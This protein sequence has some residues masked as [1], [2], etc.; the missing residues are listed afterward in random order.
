MSL[1]IAGFVSSQVQ[2]PGQ[3][4]KT[5]EAPD[6]CW[7][8][9]LN[10]SSI[11]YVYAWK[12][13]L[14]FSY[15]YY[16]TWIY[17]RY[18]D[19]TNWAER[20]IT[21]ANT[22]SSPVL[23]E[24]HGHL[25]LFWRDKDSDHIKLTTFDSNFE[26]SPV[27]DLGISPLNFYTMGSFDATV[28]KDMLYIVYVN[29]YTG[30]IDVSRCTTDPGIACSDSRAPI[31]GQ[32][33]LS[34]ING[35]YRWHL[36]IEA[37]PGTIGATAGAGLNGTF[38]GAESYL[39]IA[40]ASTES[41]RRFNHMRIDQIDLEGPNEYPFV[42]HT[43]WMPESYP[44]AVVMNEIGIEM[45]PSA[46][47]PDPPTV[48]GLN[49]IYL[50]WRSWGDNKIHKAVIQDFGEFPFSRT[51]ITRSHETPFETW[52]GVRL[53]KNPD[54]NGIIFGRTDTGYNVLNSYLP[55]RY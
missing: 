48:A 13:W 8:S 51:W 53:T 41:G 6:I 4:A 45:M 43:E 42:R 55:G 52:T 49:Y 33:W 40:S 20:V 23:V 47:Q 17:V 38:F 21:N 39:Y 50:S 19:G 15:G 9:N 18:N 25:H 37:W 46:F 26:Q 27:Y 10:T 24:Y 1:G 29:K 22:D 5:D 3:N 2:G 31:H 44:G 36:D 28:F 14:P 34:W 11:K 54:D 30:N 16:S 7:F 32:G 12:N 35:F